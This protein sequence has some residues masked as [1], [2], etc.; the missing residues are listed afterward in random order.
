M[1]YIVLKQRLAFQRTDPKNP[2][3][4]VGDEEIVER[5]GRVP[6][7]VP[8]FIVSSL[9]NAGDVVFADEPDPM[10][11]P[12]NQLAPQVRTPDQ[13]TVLPSDPNGVPPLLGDPEEPVVE[14]DEGD[15]VA[16]PATGDRKEVWEAYAQRPEIGLTQG[17]AESMNKADLMAE[18]RAR[19]DAAHS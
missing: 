13:P 11:V 8:T 17:E 16:L 4:P 10:V 9:A 2:T 18:V 1:P 12:A 15:A 7:Y 14:E 19:F 5:G 3:I 6:D